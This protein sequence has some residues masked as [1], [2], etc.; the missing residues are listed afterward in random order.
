MEDRFYCPDCGGLFAWP[1]V[2]V[3]TDHVCVCC[4]Y[5]G[6]VNFEGGDS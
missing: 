3:D 1:R 5:C 6:S 2:Y 4:P